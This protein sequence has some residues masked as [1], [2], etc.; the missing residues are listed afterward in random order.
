VL[1]GWSSLDL[2]QRYSH[3]EGRLS[4]ADASIIAPWLCGLDEPHQRRA[5]AL[6]VVGE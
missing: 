5:P 6:K 4:A 1:G 3:M 2:V